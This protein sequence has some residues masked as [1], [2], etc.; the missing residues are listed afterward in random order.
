[1]TRADFD[2]AIA[3]AMDAVT[4]DDVRGWTAHAGYT[5]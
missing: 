1:L 4:L 2:L 5:L 3:A